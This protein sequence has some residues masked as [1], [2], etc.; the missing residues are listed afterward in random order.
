MLAVYPNQIVATA[1]ALPDGVQSVTISDPSDGGYTSMADVITFGAAATDT[2]QITQS[3]PV[4]PVGGQ[5]PNPIRVTVRAADGVT[6]VDG[7]TVQWSVNNGATLSLCNATTCPAI[8]DESGHSETRVTLGA[9]GTTTVTAQLAPAAYPNKQAQTTLSSSVSSKSISLLPMKIWGTGGM[10]LNI[11]VTAR[12]L[13]TSG[14][15]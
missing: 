11:P 9:S 12:V 4:I 2:M 15:R 3:N 13:T 6:P 14:T 1:P 7:A 8:T 5:T 10:S